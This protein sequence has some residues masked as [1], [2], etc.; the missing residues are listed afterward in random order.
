MPI[1]T[2]LAGLID[3][4]GAIM[5]MKETRK[6]LKRG[7]CWHARMTISNTSKELLETIQQIIKMGKIYSV[8]KTPEGHQSAFFL[9]FSQSEMQSLFP[10]IMPYLIVKKQR[11][12]LVSKALELLFMNQYH[13]EK[14]IFNLNTKKLEQIY[15]ELRSLKSKGRRAN[16]SYNNRKTKA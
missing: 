11:V 14:R 9:K 12:I 4:E 16:I 15:L 1:W 5:F 10:H 13:R 3:G 7:F 6:D 2:W 8:G